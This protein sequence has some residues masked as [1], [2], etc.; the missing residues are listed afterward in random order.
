MEIFFSGDL[1]ELLQTIVTFVSHV[2]GGGGGP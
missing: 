1:H 2:H